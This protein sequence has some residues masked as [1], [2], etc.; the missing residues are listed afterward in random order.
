[1]STHGTGAKVDTIKDGQHDLSTSVAGHDQHNYNPQ[2][3]AGG[4]GTYLHPFEPV[5]TIITNFRPIN[6]V[7]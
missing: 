1:M 3:G 6:D 4:D 7:D 5:L 2:G